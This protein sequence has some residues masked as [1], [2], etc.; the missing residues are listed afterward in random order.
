[1][2]LCLLSLLLTSALLAIVPGGGPGFFQPTTTVSTSY[3]NTGGS[4]NRAGIVTCSSADPAFN[5]YG[6]LN[7]HA[8]NFN[9]LVNGD[10]TTNDGWF[11]A[12]SLDGTKYFT[13]D[14]GSSKVVNEIKFYQQNTAAQG[15][16]KLQGSNDGSTFTDI[17]SSFALGGAATQTITAP[18]AN[19]T[20]Y[21]YLR[22]T[23]VSGS[24]S[25]GP[26]VYQFDFKISP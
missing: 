10:Y 13:F 20:A 19:T 3:A 5:G 23:G 11:Q 17:G 6:T 22:F 8:G 2:K 14:F 4:G 7:G 12:L 9:R 15:T 26:Y 25:S 24:S 16:W 1:M 18:S 21:R